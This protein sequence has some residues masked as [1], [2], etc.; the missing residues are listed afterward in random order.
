MAF[1]FAMTLTFDVW[2]WQRLLAIVTHVWRLLVPSFIEIPPLG[3][4]P[5]L[6]DTVW[7][8]HWP[9]SLR[10][11]SKFLPW[12]WLLRRWML[13]SEEYYCISWWCVDTEFYRDIGA[14]HLR[15]LFILWLHD[16]NYS[17]L[18]LWQEKC[19]ISN[20][21]NDLDISSRWP[22]VQSPC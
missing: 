4:I 1:H 12:P 21:M 8:W 11:K 13:A 6:Q 17:R 9:W 22:W 18:Y 16:L 15:P 2:P 20:V 3:E 14:I 7:P 10:P 19:T 5:P